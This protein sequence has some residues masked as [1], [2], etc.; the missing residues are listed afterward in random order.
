MAHTPGPWYPHP[1]DHDAE[2]LSVTTGDEGHPIVC[3]VWP[4]GEDFEDSEECP[5]RASNAHLI[6]A[7]PE[8]LAALIRLEGC[9]DLNLDEL[10]NRAFA[11]FLSPETLKAIDNARAA[12]A[13][14]KGGA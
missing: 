7:A 6:S 8:L 9:P 2:C 11:G 4:M 13:K 3:E 10:Q 14:A 1:S 12:I 5:T